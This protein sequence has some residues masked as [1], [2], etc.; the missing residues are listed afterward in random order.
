MIAKAVELERLQAQLQLW[1]A[2]MTHLGA[3]IGAPPPVGSP[4][5][6]AP[7]RAALRAELETLREL[8][9]EAELTLHRLERADDAEWKIL[10]ER[11]EA[12]LGRLGAAFEQ[13]RARFGE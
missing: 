6:E 10:L 5:L 9:A 1:N 8:W 4:H 7:E 3:K 11:T 2:E 13:S 12:D